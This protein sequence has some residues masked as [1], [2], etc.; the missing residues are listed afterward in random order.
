MTYCGLMVSMMDPN[1]SE[2][3]GGREIK[4]LITRL[5]FFPDITSRRFFCWSLFLIELMSDR[6]QKIALK[7]IQGVIM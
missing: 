4:S 3:F 6:P 2:L 1:G 5:I 7:L